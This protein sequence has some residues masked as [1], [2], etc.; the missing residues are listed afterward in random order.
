MKDSGVSKALRTEVAKVE[1]N[2]LF[3]RAGAHLQTSDK[4]HIMGHLQNIKRTK[5][6]RASSY[7]LWKDS[8]D[9]LK[10]DTALQSTYFN[11]ELL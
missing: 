11:N 4:S 5:S 6:Y 10:R 2:R 9:C 3:S 7:D 8:S 1:R